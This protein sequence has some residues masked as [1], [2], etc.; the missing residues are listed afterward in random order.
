V[1]FLGASVL[2][3]GTMQLA[4]TENEKRDIGGAL[5][6]ALAYFD[7]SAPFVKLLNVLGPW[8]G[9][10]DGLAAAIYSRAIYIAEHRRPSITPPRMDTQRIEAPAPGNGRASFEDDEIVAPDPAAFYRT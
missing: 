6:D 3:T 4:A 2:L 1:L 10:I 7:D 8:S 5:S 9:V